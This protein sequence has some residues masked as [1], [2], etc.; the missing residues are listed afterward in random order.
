M[1]DSCS[2]SVPHLDSNVNV[3]VGPQNELF[4]VP[5]M[6]LFTYSKY[7]AQQLK[8]PE[9]WLQLW[10]D[11]PRTF[12]L[13][14]KWI[15]NGSRALDLLEQEILSKVDDENRLGDGCHLFCD[16]YCL[17]IKLE[18]MKDEFDVVDKIFN[19]LRHGHSLPLQPRTIRMVHRKLPEGSMMLD[20]LLKE[21][22]D[23]LVA[24]NGHNYDYYAELLEGP[25]AIPGLMKALFIRMKKPKLRGPQYR[26]SAS[27]G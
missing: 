25:T 20:H 11:E 4:V 6:L 26:K 10:T 27:R 13:L 3:Y 5:R 15:Q 22:A 14:L 18:V 9:N 8:Q 7:F 12:K 19:L 1:A 17:Y 23:D 24:E 16:L 21:L 2:C